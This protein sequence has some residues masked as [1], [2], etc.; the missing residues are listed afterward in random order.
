MPA[1]SMG[2]DENRFWELTP[3]TIQP[4]FKAYKKI[5]ERQQQD[6]WLIG[7]RV[8]EALISSFK[9]GKE[10]PPPYPKMPFTENIEDELVKDE[11]WVEQQRAKAYAHFMALAQA[12]K[13]R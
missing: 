7:F 8:R 10:N 13:R 5:R 12:S 6:I 2:I 3:K 11:K 4:Y 1:L 9:F